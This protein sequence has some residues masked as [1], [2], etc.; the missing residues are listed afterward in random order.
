MRAEIE[1]EV[2][3]SRDQSFL[4]SYYNGPDIRTDEWAEETA[5][6][7][8]RCDAFPH[9][10]FYVLAGDHREMYRQL[11]GDGWRK[12]FCYFRDNFNTHGI[13]TSATPET[14]NG[15]EPN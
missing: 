2:I 14:P 15:M 5:L 10:V 11:I 4:V 13:I 12:C 9:K 7:P 3:V 1:R 8:K 6:V